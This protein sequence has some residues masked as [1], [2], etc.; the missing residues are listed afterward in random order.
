MYCIDSYLILIEIILENKIC[1][2][3]NLPLG[4]EEWRK[5][6]AVVIALHIFSPVTV[7]VNRSV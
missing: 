1:V 4:G 3:Y 2:Y 6:V 5:V 7:N